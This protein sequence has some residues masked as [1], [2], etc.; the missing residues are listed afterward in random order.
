MWGDDSI[1]A[2]LKQMASKIIFWEV[3]ALKSMAADSFPV[4]SCV[5]RS[6]GA[7]IRPGAAPTVMIRAPRI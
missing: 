4:I 5:T 3:L 7:S 1:M 2:K 6:G